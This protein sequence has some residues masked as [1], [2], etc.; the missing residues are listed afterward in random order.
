MN[1]FFKFHPKASAL[2]FI[3]VLAVTMFNVNPF[4]VISLA[5]GGAAFSLALGKRPT[6]RSLSLYALLFAAVSLT[7]PLFSTHGSTKLFTVLSHT[8]TLEALLYGVN[9]G[10]TLVA[11]LLWFDNLTAVLDEGKL[12]YLLSGVSPKIALVVTSALSF[13]PRL[14]VLSESVR[15]ANKGIGGKDNINLYTAL[16]GISL[17]NAADTGLSMLS[18][19]YGVAKRTHYSP[20][21]FTARDALFM[22]ATLTLTAA[23]VISKLKGAI[24]FEFY[25]TLS[26]TFSPVALVAVAALSFMP[27]ILTVIKEL[28]WKYCISKI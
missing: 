24:G 2:Y 23:F 16:V 4:V 22:T 5:L 10:M 18:R 1:G 3:A 8:I 25:P 20:Y 17:E 15:N 26:G 11:V 6:L 14:R 27:S 19:G 21:K 13:V 7:N 28:K 9:L 12:L